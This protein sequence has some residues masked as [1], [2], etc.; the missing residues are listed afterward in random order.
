MRGSFAAIGSN[1]FLS[2]TTDAS[3][4]SPSGRIAPVGG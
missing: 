1:R 2:I 4:P 3:R